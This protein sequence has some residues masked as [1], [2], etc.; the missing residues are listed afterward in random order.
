MAVPPE[1]YTTTSYIMEAMPL[2]MRLR[3]SQV[4]VWCERLGLP[5]PS[6]TLT[7]FPD[8]DL[9][10]GSRDILQARQRRVLRV[11]WRA[12][13]GWG[14]GVSL[15]A[16][17]DEQGNVTEVHSRLIPAVESGVMREMRSLLE[18]CWMGM[19]WLTRNRG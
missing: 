13:T 11:E 16:E 18:D 7:A 19:G 2:G 10:F 8:D 4:A 14:Q 3:V 1:R 9:A 6:L 17:I 5:I 12:T 15:D